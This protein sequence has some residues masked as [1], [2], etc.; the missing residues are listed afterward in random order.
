MTS[1]HRD[2]RF[3]TILA[4]INDLHVYELLDVF[5]PYHDVMKKTNTNLYKKKKKVLMMIKI[6]KNHRCNYTQTAKV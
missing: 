2:G 4:F 1:D 3:T 6:W 5:S